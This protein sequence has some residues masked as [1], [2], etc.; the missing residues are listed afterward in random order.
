[1][2]EA[3]QKESQTFI[4]NYEVKS[5]PVKKTAKG[6]LR[7]VGVEI[8]FGGLGA[9]QAAITVQNALS[10]NIKELNSN[11]YTV[12]ET[13]IG[14]IE[15]IVDSR[16]LQ[17]SSQDKNWIKELK[18]KFGEKLAGLVPIEIITEPIP[19]T[20]LSVIDNLVSKLRERDAKGT[21]AS[22]FF[23]YGMH[24]NV[25]AI[26]LQ[27]KDIIPIV[28]AWGL[29]GPYI[30]RQNG[31]D[32]SRK[33]LPYIDQYPASYIDILAKKHYSP[34]WPDFMA[35]YAEHNPT[36][37][38]DLDMIPLMRSIDSEMV[39]A[40]LPKDHSK[41]RPAFHWRMPDTR[42]GDPDW[43][44]SKNWNDWIEIEELAADSTK[45]EALASLWRKHRTDTFDFRFWTNILEKHYS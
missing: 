14:N 29:W 10:G 32:L 42:L 16:Y 30:A 18:E 33:V 21:S 37:N 7:K 9:R 1:M 2:K 24:L 41:K 12:T 31:I 25:E 20:K 45:L 6:D 35:C 39:E 34:S 44:P 19:Y 3:K 38:R 28:R 23:A 40:L 4:P 22:P 36:R 8:E 43:K 5:P 27:I 13:I 26:S 15:I 11:K 17:P